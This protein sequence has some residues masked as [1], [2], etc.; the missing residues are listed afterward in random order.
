MTDLG[1]TSGESGAEPTG[2]TAIETAGESAGQSVAPAQTAVNGTEQDGESFFDYESIR[3][4]PNEAAYKEMQRA[5]SKKTEALKG[6]ADKIAQFDQFMQDPVSQMQNLA[7]QYG[8][9]MVQG[10]AETAD[11][12]PKTF[13]SWD[14]V[15]S[16]AKTQVMAELQPMFGELQNM[17]M[18]NGEQS[19]DNS[20]PDWRIYEDAM[21]TTLKDH[22]T[23]VGNP[24]LLYRMSVPETVLEARANKAAL[25]KIQG[26]TASSKVQGQ[27]TTTQ[28]PSK[29]PGKLSFNE[30]VEYARQE[31]SRRGLVR[32]SG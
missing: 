25:A 9:Q 14:D 23:L 31:V 10:Q 21:M 8:Y 22:P 18:Q 32:P 19:L 11:G 1:E 2:T 30:A 26:T 5:F 4:T 16:E 6:G 12:K 15:M 24:D 27:S 7:R 20:H 3:G 28:Q 29:K 17:K 13:E